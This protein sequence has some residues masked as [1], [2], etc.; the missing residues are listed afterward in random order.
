[1]SDILPVMII[2]GLIFCAVLSLVYFIMPKN[3]KVFFIAACWGMGIGLYLQ[4]NFLQIQYGVLDGQK[5]D[6]GAYTGYGVV[7]TLFWIVCVVSPLIFCVVRKS[8][9]KKI[10]TFSSCIII[11]V[12]VVTLAFLGI[13]TKVEK[14]DIAVT[15]EGIYT[16]SKNKNIVVFILDGF[17]QQYMNELLRN[18]S[19][20]V[21][22]FEGFTY[23]DNTAG[24]YQFTIPTIAYLLTGIKYQNETPFAEYKENA[25]EQTDL[26]KILKSKNYIAGIYTQSDHLGSPLEKYVENVVVED[27]YVKDLVSFT[28]KLY[29]L[30]ATKYFPH[31]LKPVIWL[32]SKAF[33][34]YKNTSSRTVYRID[35]VYFNQQLLENDLDYTN[36]SNIFRFYHLQGAHTPYIYNENVERIQDAN[37]YVQ[38]KGSLQVVLNYIA[39]LKEGGIY[40]DT[41]M[42]V[43]ADHGWLFRANPLFMVKDFY[44]K[45]PFSISS[46]PV[47]Y[48][49]FSPMLN[50]S[51]TV[52]GSCESFLY[53][54][55]KNNDRRYFYTNSSFDKDGF[56]TN[57]MEWVLVDGKNTQ[58]HLETTGRMLIAGNLKKDN[59]YRF[60][61]TIKFGKDG[62]AIKYIVQGFSTGEDSDMWWS[63]GGNGMMEMRLK[64]LPKKDVL[65]KVEGRI[66]TPS[67]F[68]LSQ[69]I[70]ISVNGQF[71]EEKRLTSGDWSF[72]IPREYITDHN[73]RLQFEYPDALTPFELGLSE[74]DTRRLAVGYHTMTLLEL[75]Q[76]AFG[77]MITFGKGGN[78]DDY[79]NSAGL[80]GKESWGRW[81]YGKTGSMSIRLAALPKGDVEVN[82]EGRLYV[83]KGVLDHQRVRILANGQFI[84]EKRLTSGDWSFVVPRGLITE[85]TLNLSFEYPDAASPVDLGLS[86][87]T[88]LLAVGYTSMTILG[89]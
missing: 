71:I 57:F 29:Q 22:Q 84:V 85:R 21:H 44:S 5:I 79:V 4:G 55:S 54:A 67:K 72:V 38:S 52:A 15:T 88:R 45:K 19:E 37:V 7:N 16:L 58:S 66:Y 50:N 64:S 75:P 46:I 27:M 43:M 28:Q 31:I 89:K 87:D 18:D 69:T 23:Y 51:I 34:G 24:M 2:S 14:K 47:T 65:V 49:D 83:P 40:D 12:Q 6:W 62:N 33:D 68:R 48:N 77:D 1:M 76:Y 35:D 3:M 36:G 39:K 25:F 82:I 70:R 32:Y 17:D 30:V 10:I 56:F 20:F 86:A 81:S 80:S 42:I 26:Y 61:G 9:L 60:G 11:A 78:A 13:T 74:N 63:L 8:A 73:L 53:E 41:L 59:A